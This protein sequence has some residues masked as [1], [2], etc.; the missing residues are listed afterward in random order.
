[1]PEVAVSDRRVALGDL[2]ERKA[3]RVVAP[4]GFLVLG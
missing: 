1:M 4:S 3:V 2:G